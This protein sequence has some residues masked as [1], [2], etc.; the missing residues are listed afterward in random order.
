M[1]W[2]IC[3]TCRAKKDEG[4]PT[5]SQQVSELPP[6]SVQ[7]PS[8]ASYL[9]EPTPMPDL[10]GTPSPRAIRAMKRQCPN[11]K[12]ECHSTEWCHRDDWRDNAG[13][14]KGCAGKCK[15]CGITKL[16]EAYD[17]YR[18]NNARSHKRDNLFCRVCMQDIHRC[19]TCGAEGDKGMFNSKSLDHA[20]QRGKETPEKGLKLKKCLKCYNASKPAKEKC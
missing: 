16:R 14:C 9:S 3:P 15:K 17:S 2:Y 18:W 12:A 4:P 5:E 20:K 10:S 1:P 19:G 6:E 8:P 13:Y 7:E 11:C